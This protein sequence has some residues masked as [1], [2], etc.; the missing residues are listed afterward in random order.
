MPRLEIPS[1]K[2]LGSWDSLLPSFPAA[3]G[4]LG[5]VLI[6]VKRLKRD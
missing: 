4:I 6:G 2:A 5:V 3:Q 1:E